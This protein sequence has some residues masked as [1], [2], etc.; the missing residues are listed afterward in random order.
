MIDGRSRVLV[1]GATGLVGKSLLQHAPRGISLTATSRQRPIWQGQWVGFDLNRVERIHPW[2][3]ALSPD[4]IIHTAA[5]SGIAQAAADKLVAR[6]VNVECVQAIGAW[7]AANNCRLIHFSTDFVFDGKQGMYSESDRPNPIN[8]YGQTKLTADEWLLRHVPNLVIVRTVLVYGD[9]DTL[10]RP[11]FYT[12]VRDSLR[13]G[14]SLEITAD[15]WRTPTLVDDLAQAVWQLVNIDCGGV[16]N[17]CGPQYLSVF[18]FAAII[19]QKLGLDGSLLHPVNTPT[20]NTDVT[21]PL[22]T[23]L[24]IDLAMK[25]IGFDPCDVEAGID[26]LINRGKG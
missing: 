22:K 10:V 7:C 4:C 24:K 11:N 23:G 6:R 19:A 13:A 20:T 15:Q 2:L 25:L 3:D 17:L 21:R 26:R 12:L 8:F 16:I 5:I 9:H 1:T 14:K 18:D